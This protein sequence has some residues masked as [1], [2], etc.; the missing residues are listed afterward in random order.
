M[1]NFYLRFIPGA[2]SIHA[3]LND[4]L[5]GNAKWRAPV[6]WNSVADAAFDQRK[7]ALPRATLLAHPKP[8]APLAIFTDASDIAIGA[9]LQQHVKGAWQPLYLRSAENSWQCTEQ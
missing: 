6:T 1:V 4:L 8:D 7:D 3:P 2:A 5:Q 9:V